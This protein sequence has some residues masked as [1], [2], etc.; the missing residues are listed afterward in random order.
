MATTSTFCR[1]Q[2][3]LQRE[4]AANT[5]LE[6]VRMIATTAAIAWGRE[7]DL[8]EQRETKRS[9]DKSLPCPGSTSEELEDLFFNENP[10]RGLLG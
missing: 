4:R 9:F 2:E 8:A 1:A 7:A 10:D 3:A 5:S 6:N